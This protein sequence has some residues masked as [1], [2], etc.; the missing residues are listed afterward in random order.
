MRL[1]T[2]ASLVAVLALTAACSGGGGGGS[3]PGTGPGTAISLGER[4]VP[5]YKLAVSRDGGLVTLAVTPLDGA[6]APA[7]V[8]ALIGAEADWDLAVAGQ[9]F[10]G[11]RYAWTIPTGGTGRVWVR[12]TDAEGDE[13]ESGYEDFA[14]P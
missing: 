7:S 9:D 11:N 4:E 14:L 12:I 13:M 2:T 1:I 6:A 5:G 8:E 3:G 10:G